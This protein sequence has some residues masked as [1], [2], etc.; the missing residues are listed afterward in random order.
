MINFS[1]FFN[2]NTLSLC[3]KMIMKFLR[4]YQ[5]N[6]KIK[7]GWKGDGTENIHEYTDV[8]AKD[9]IKSKTIIEL[10]NIKNYKWVY[11]LGKPA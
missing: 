4:S 9:K 1:I 7:A 6:I 3:K 8:Y 10:K 5:I 11:F 2:S